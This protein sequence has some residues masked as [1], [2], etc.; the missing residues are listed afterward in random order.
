MQQLVDRVEAL[1]EERKA[2]QRAA[3]ALAPEP[4]ECRR[5]RLADARRNGSEAVL[6]R[7]RVVR[8]A[9]AD[10]VHESGVEAGGALLGFPDQLRPAV[11]VVESGN[12]TVDVE[13][14]QRLP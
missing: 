3:A 11:V 2:E 14:L 12:A 13:R 4:H 9:R 6:R 7:V 8:V 5:R 10:E 1:V